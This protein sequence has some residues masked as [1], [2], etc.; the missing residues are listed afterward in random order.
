MCP[1]FLNLVRQHASEIHEGVSAAT[2]S[3]NFS[4][5]AS[6]A[7]RSLRSVVK[8]S[9][10]IARNIHDAT[11]LREIL[12]KNQCQPSKTASQNVPSRS[13]N[14]PPPPAKCCVKNCCPC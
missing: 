12:K 9:N 4:N 14:F 10:E 6:T 7:P 8:S 11:S 2:S 1:P 13:V 5:N 3:P